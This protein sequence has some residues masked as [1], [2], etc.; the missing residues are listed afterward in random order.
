MPR[1][2]CLSAAAKAKRR[3]GKKKETC[4]HN[5]NQATAAVDETQSSPSST[6]RRISKRP[7]LRTTIEQRKRKYKAH[8]VFSNVTRSN[9]MRKKYAENTSFRSLWRKRMQ[10]KYVHDAVFHAHWQRRMRQKYRSNCTFRCLWRKKMQLTRAEKYKDSAFRDYW[11]A[12]MRTKYLDE[13]FREQWRHTMR[14]KYKDAAFREH[15]RSQ[16][17]ASYTHSVSNRM[18]KK[19]RVKNCRARQAATVKTCFNSAIAVFRKHIQE[20]PIFTCISCHRHLYRQSVSG[21]KMSKYKRDS[22]AILDRIISAFTNSDADD[23]RYV[24][25]T[26][27]SYLVRGKLPPQAAVNG[28]LLE[29]IPSALRVTE[30]ESVLIAQR[31]LFMKLMALPRGRQR[32][33]HGAVVNVPSNVSSTVTSLPLTPSKACTVAAET[34]TSTAI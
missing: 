22:N 4:A 21:F 11:R 24:C 3:S 1:T 6:R 18:L 8:A 33:I 32:A 15:C 29:N 27:H 5:Y 31:V 26:C 16:M 20:G 13:T 30:L 12:E 23:K 2:K 9:A 17:R 19:Q 10:A 7:T 34:E 28:L 25:I 14:A